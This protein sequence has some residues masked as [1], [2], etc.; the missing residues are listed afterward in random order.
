MYVYATCG[1]SMCAQSVR[2]VYIPSVRVWE[3]QSWLDSMQWMLDSQKLVKQAHVA[4]YATRPCHCGAPEHEGDC[5]LCSD[6]GEV[7]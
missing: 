3:L 6:K 5:M 4:V 2:H 1:A 7:A